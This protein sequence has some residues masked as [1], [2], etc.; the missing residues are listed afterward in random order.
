MSVTVKAMAEAYLNLTGLDGLCS[1]QDDC[2]C[3]AADL[4]PCDSEHIAGCVAGVK[5]PCNPDYCHGD[6]DCDFHI[7]PAPKAGEP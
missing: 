3:E 1:A 2:A 4:M 7:E 6:G 5:V